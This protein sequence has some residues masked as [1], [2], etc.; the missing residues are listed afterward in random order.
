M[1]PLRL[2]YSPLASRTALQ[3]VGTPQSMDGVR[4]VVNGVLLTALP[5]YKYKYQASS[6]CLLMFTA[7]FSADKQR[8][9]SLRC[10]SVLGLE[11]LKKNTHC[12]NMMRSPKFNTSV[13]CSSSS[14]LDG[15]WS[16]E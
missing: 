9:K 1:E 8:V 10:T 14:S 7:N 15:F 4:T 3:W 5:V 11:R 12:F 16:G 2:H 13:R 6:T